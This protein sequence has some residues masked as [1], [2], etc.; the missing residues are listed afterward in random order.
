MGRQQALQLMKEMR[1]QRHLP[2]SFTYWGAISACSEGA[3]WGKALDLLDEMWQTAIA[4][5]ENHFAVAMKICADAGQ[6][7]E[8]ISLFDTMMQVKIKPA[9]ASC[10]TALA[11]C[12][13]VDRWEAA[14][15]VLNK[16]RSMLMEVSEEQA[17]GSV[18]SFAGPFRDNAPELVRELLEQGVTPVE[19]AI[20]LIHRL[21]SPR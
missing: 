4:P 2:N 16:H 10:S 19:A 11:A 3:S 21:R 17:I 20:E 8:A 15:R 18:R 12:E 6:G 13:A 5:N 7:N 1:Q 9:K 14:L